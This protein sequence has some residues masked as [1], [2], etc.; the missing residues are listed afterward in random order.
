MSAP[1]TAV[2]VREYCSEV[3]SATT[4]ELGNYYS[5]AVRALLREKYEST[6]KPAVPGVCHF[7]PDGVSGAAIPRY[8]AVHIRRGDVGKET[9]PSRFTS[10]EAHAPLIAELLRRHPGMPVIIFSQ[11]E[12]DDFHDLANDSPEVS[13]RVRLC[14]EADVRTTFHALVSAHA[15]LVAKSSYSYSAAILTRGV[16]YADTIRKWWHQ[17]LPSY[18]SSI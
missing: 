16:V 4:A 8:V 6:P 1:S 2:D 14:L 7:D 15:L 5:D 12:P 3:H 13:G 18:S 11:G 17:P 10:N 9:Y